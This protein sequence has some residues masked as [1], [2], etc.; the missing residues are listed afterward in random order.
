MPQTDPVKRREYMKNYRANHP[1]YREKARL[2][3]Q[4]YD[5]EHN[6]QAKRSARQKE[7]LQN[8]PEFAERRRAQWRVYANTNRKELEKKKYEWTYAGFTYEDR[9]AMLA[10]QGFKCVICDRDITKRHMTDHCHKNGHVRGMLCHNCNTL[11]GLSKDNPTVL[12]AAAEYLERH[13]TNP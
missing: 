12:R 1:E 13:L 5:A 10:V 9:D 6:T 8:D 3:A 11:L 2:Y 7:R 4:Q